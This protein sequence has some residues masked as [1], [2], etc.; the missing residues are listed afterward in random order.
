MR[1]ANEAHGRCTPEKEYSDLHAAEGGATVLHCNVGGLKVPSRCAKSTS[2]V[3]AQATGD[4]LTLR[5][6]SLM[7]FI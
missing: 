4:S 6:R 1:R 3:D 7:H 5:K 2:D